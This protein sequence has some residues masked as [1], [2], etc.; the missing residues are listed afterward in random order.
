MKKIVLF[1]QIIFSFL[2]VNSQNTAYGIGA[3]SNNTSGTLNSA[4]GTN[5]LFNNTVG[6]NNIAVG[7]FALIANINGGLNIGIGAYVLGNNTNGAGNLAIGNYA[8]NNNVSGLQNIAIGNHAMLNNT[9][10][11]SNLASGVQSLYN[12]TTGRF[13]LAIG[14]NSGYSLQTGSYNTVIG[15]D[16]FA[17]LGLV[18]GSSNTIIG[19]RISGLP[20]NLSNTIVLADGSGNQ[21]LYIDNNG[22]AGLGT[23]SPNSTLEINSNVSSTSGLRFTQLS[24]STITP[25]NNGKTLS[26]DATGNVILTT[27]PGAGGGGLNWSLTGNSGTVNGTHFIGTTDNVPF[28]IRVNN[29]QSGKIDGTSQNV[30][31][32]Y[33]SGIN[34]NTTAPNNSGTQNV[35]IGDQAL[36]SSQFGFANTAVGYN[37]MYSLVG[38]T[39]ST[40]SGNVAVGWRTLYLATGGSYN[41]AIGTMALYNDLG[42]EANSALGYHAL[43][44]NTTGNNNTGVG[45]QTLAYNLTGSYNSGLGYSANVSLS[46]FQHA[47]AIGSYAI[48]NASNKIVIGDN[49]PGIVIGGY[50][51]WSNL[52]DGRF[53][54]NVNED[55]PGLT[56][57]T[58]LRPVTYTINTEKLD[59]HI[60]QSMPDSNLKARKIKKQE[61]YAQAAAKIQT[62]FIAQEVEKTAKE[63]GYNF[64]GVNAP[65]NLT[66]NYSIAYSQFVVPLV[67]AVQ[68]LS[69]QNDDLKREMVELRNLIKGNTEGS[70]QLTESNGTAKLFQNTPNPFSKLTIIRYTIPSTTKNAMISITSL[71]GVKVKEFDLKN[72]AGQRIE[73]IGGQLSPGTYIYS[74]LLDGRLVDSKKMILTQ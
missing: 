48:A 31:L 69:K 68:E 3:L 9:T 29:Q 16:L 67:K 13:N 8:M 56:F 15:H 17:N 61:S 36:F 24:S 33:Q 46:N 28:N 63:I 59:E 20:A 60:M 21:R 2:I 5:A 54:E 37:A 32:G 71:G 30:F 6:N 65:K 52:S 27:T 64:D 14:H 34:N 53:K 39:T 40:H 70:I 18:S 4:F 22:N 66:D 10:G 45:V 7:E 44:G 38:A 51:A 47:T 26:V 11:Q 74:L 55:V 72:N 12:N 62:G 50:A 49:T 35:A 58:K 73:I 1:T 42:T 25:V 43:I 23:T 41:T 57:I 19:S